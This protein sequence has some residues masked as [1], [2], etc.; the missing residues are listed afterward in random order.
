V[1]DRANAALPELGA[2]AA[3]PELVRCYSQRDGRRR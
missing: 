1:P 3:L 2:N